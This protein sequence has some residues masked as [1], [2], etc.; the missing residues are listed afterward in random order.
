VK[1]K[2]SGELSG[3]KIRLV[4]GVPDFAKAAEKAGKKILLDKAGG[5]LDRFLGK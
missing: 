4:D 1:I 5:F 3:P 2:S